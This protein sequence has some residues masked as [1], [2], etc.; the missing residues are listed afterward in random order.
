MTARHDGEYSLAEL[1]L[2]REGRVRAIE[3]GAELR[4]R[5]QE[6]GV[7]VGTIVRLTRIA[8]L[9]DPL[10]IEVRGYRL[11][12]RRADARGIHLAHDPAG[13]ALT[14]PMAAPAVA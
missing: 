1:P 10:E 6:M 7:I 11:S 3:V 14:A 8:P 13:E 9:G 4:R 5:L 12:V 2:G